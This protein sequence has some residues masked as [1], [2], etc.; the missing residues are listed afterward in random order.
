MAF[1]GLLPLVA[2]AQTGTPTVSGVSI[3]STP[4][5]GDTYGPP[6]AYG[7]S[8]EVIDIEVRFSETVTVTGTPQLELDIG[9]QARQADYAYGSGSSALWFSYE[10]QYSD[11]DTNGIAIGANA[12]TLNSGAIQDSDSNNATL[13]LGS[14][15]I[16][17]DA[18][19]KVDG[20]IRLDFT[21]SPQ[22]GG[23]TYGVNEIIQVRVGFGDDLSFTPSTPNGLGDLQLGLMIGSNTRQLRAE[24][25]LDGFSSIGEASF[26]YEIQSGDMDS[27]GLGIAAGALTVTGGTL[28]DTGGNA[29]RLNFGTFAVTNDAGRKINGSVDDAPTVNEVQSLSPPLIGQ[30]FVADERI[31]I[32]LQFGEPVAITGRPQVALTVGN[33]TRQ[34]VY[35]GCNGPAVEG[36]CS[37]SLVFS[38]VVRSADV[39]ADGV[40]IA[41]GA[42]ALNGGAI[43]DRGGNNANL[44]L[45]TRARAFGFRRF[46]VNGG[47][48]RAPNLSS[49]FRDN[50]G[51]VDGESTYQAP[52]VISDPQGSSTFGATET[53][54]VSLFFNE[55]VVVTGSPQLALGIGTSTRQADYQGC[56]IGDADPPGT[57]RRL[58]F[59]Y[60][61]QSSDS[62]PNGISIA[63]NAL[64]LN[65][66]TIRDFG[67]NN[68]NRDLG[69]NAVTNSSGHKVDGSVNRT[70][71]VAGASLLSSPQEGDTYGFGETIR[72]EVRFDE[73]VTVTGS[74]QLALAINVQTRQAAYNGGSGTNALTFAYAVQSTDADADGISIAANALALNSGTIVDSGGQ[75]AGLNLGTHAVSNSSGHKVDGSVDRAPAVSGAAVTS[76]PVGGG[77][78]RG[79]ETIEVTVTYNEPVTVAGSPQLA[80]FVGGRTRQAGYQRC[81]GNPGDPAGTCRRLVFGYEVRAGDG[82]AV[83][84]GA[85]SLNGG[86][87]VDSGSNNA[88][89]DL[90]SHAV[91][92]EAG[93]RAGD[94]APSGGGGTPPP[95]ANKVPVAVGEFDDLDLGPGESAEVSLLGKFRDPEGGALAYSAESLNP[96]VANAVVSEG[97]LWVDGRSAGLATVLVKATDSGGL[98]AQQAFQ[99]AVGRVLTFAESVAAV[100]EGG[101]ARL[102]VELSRP[103]E[104]TVSVGYVLE[105]D[106][107]PSTADADDEDHRGSDGTLA[108][109]AGETEA[110][111]EV[112]ILDDGD[113]EP[114]RE[115]LRVR[116]L[117]PA[118]ESDWALGL[119]TAAVVIQEGVCD[120]TPEVR[121]ALRGARECWALSAGDLAGRG[122]LNLG[123]Q[124]IASLRERDLLGLAGL[125]VLH[126][127]GNRLAELPSGLFAGLGSLQRLRLDGN[128]LTELPED[129]FEGLGRLS[130]LNL[131]GNR[132]SSLPAGL[133]ADVPLLSRLHLGGNHLAELPDRFF[134]GASNLSELDLSGN[135]GAPFT[136]TMELTRTDAEDYAPGPAIVVVQV[137]EGAPFALSA[138]LLA[139]GAELSTDTAAIEDGDVSSAPIQVSL[140]EGGAAL[141][142]LSGAPE[143]P[144][145]Q[146]GEVDEGR[147][148]CFQGLRVE[149]GSR[150]LLFKR[151]PWVAQAIPGQGVESLDNALSLDLAGFFGADGDDA[152]TYSA[153]SSDPTLASVNVSGDVL[154]IEPNGQGLEGFVTVTLTATDSDGLEVEHSFT[155]EVSPPS[156]RFSRGWRLGLLMGAPAPSAEA[157]PAGGEPE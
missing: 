143:A 80:L 134:E 144:S 151:P 64:T 42:L 94:A 57:C 118:T 28:T 125:R 11:V 90:G 117:A 66:G 124:G 65:S 120:R 18:N 16:S 59:G 67:G 110:F 9:G 70:P 48:D 50:W 101:M 75:N 135:P 86:S 51:Y 140:A 27:D 1:A 129:L 74:P 99:V 13:G 88:N 55:P 36:F 130:S 62:D 69:T 33:Q 43:R 91:A 71:A 6:L 139:E 8:S 49:N 24:T 122:Y 113:I 119:A 60:T 156:W 3:A 148:P 131:G 154:S 84:T 89:L 108:L 26:L 32:F 85:L 56:T 23:D 45:G 114:A 97:R 52:L 25:P 4:A 21:G 37:K 2:G 29:A 72:A 100:P 83:S 95:P 112:P 128:R 46:R 22:D 81:S 138:G 5:R 155:V 54:E 126:L 35:V 137:A 7:V 79:G 20:R 40:T 30:T 58:T 157:V 111:I 82:G 34:A 115:H 102:Q 146:C 109:A 123:R 39:D 73:A 103:S 15:A 44:D 145:Q 98:S 68:A 96:K 141:L 107:D 47:V 106:G 104:R 93:H 14:H 10:V 116:L 87:I 153:E 17:N 78:Y 92:S 61:V 149:A 133:L 127:H 136:L 152:L 150:L 76:S 142:S 38:Y 31:L 77:G 105:S 41:A 12:L 19:H 132:L 63:A 53:I 121:D 147:Y